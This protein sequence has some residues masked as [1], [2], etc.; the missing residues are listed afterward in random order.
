MKISAKIFAL[1]EKCRWN[2]GF[3]GAELFVRASEKCRREAG[4]RAANA[5]KNHRREACRTAEKNYAPE[6]FA[7]ALIASASRKT[8]ESVPTDS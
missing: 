3:C 4:A 8:S 7:G 5:G 6:A 2:M 1:C